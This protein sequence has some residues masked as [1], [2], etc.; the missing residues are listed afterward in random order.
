MKVRKVRK[1]KPK[2]FVSHTVPILFHCNPFP[3]NIK[4]STTT[5]FLK[6]KTDRE[7]QG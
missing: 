4:P 2:N 7:C 3:Q 5:Y 6:T 1:T